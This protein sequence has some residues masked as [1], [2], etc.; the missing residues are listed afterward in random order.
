MRQAIKLKPG[1][2]KDKDKYFDRLLREHAE[3]KAKEH[4]YVIRK[5]QDGELLIDLDCEED[6]VLLKEHLDTFHA[7]V[8]PIEQVE[9][10]PSP[11]GSPG[12]YHAVVTLGRAISPMERIA[13]QAVLGSDRKRELLSLA[14]LEHEIA[15]PTIFFEKE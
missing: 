5:P 10:T 2:V 9:V 1:D 6:F 15:L 3:S 11:S 14:R 12:H 4:G 7:Y 8:V 13:Y